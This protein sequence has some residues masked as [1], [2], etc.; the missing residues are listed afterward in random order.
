MRVEKGSGPDR[1]SGDQPASAPQRS[2]AGCWF[3]GQWLGARL[4]TGLVLRI[5]FRTISLPKASEDKGFR[6]MGM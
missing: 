4:W 3:G 5:H 2:A 6:S 1:Q